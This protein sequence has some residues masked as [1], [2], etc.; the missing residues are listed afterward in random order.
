[1]ATEPYRRPAERPPTP[2]A[3]LAL[4]QPNAKPRDAEQDDVT[5][6]L[7]LGSREHDRSDRGERLKQLLMALAVLGITFLLVLLFHPR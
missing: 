4:E 7:S 5:R 6:G 3:A 2:D 1:M